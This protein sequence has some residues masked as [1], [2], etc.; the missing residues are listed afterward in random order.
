MGAMGALLQHRLWPAPAAVAS[1][2]RA[3]GC[4]SM[5]QSV[6]LHTA[7]LVHLADPPN[8]P[9]PRALPLQALTP[10][11]EGILQADMKR[12]REYALAQQN[13]QA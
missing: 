5:V 6:K 7:V 1:A 12:F 2:C 4:M 8:A 10:L 11:V 9:P 13:V 3:V